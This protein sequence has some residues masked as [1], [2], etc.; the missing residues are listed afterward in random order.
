MG[1]IFNQ[2]VVAHLPEWGKGFREAIQAMEAL[3]QDPVFGKTISGPSLLMVNGQC[4]T[5]LLGPD[6]SKEGWEESD[7]GD[8]F[9]Q[10][11]LEAAALCERSSVLHW[12]MGGD[13]G[14]TQILFQTDEA[15][16]GDTEEA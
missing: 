9:R 5:W 12:T 3:Q 2:F 8:A 10:R 7:R 14:V 11:F 13:D 16:T 15:D 4:Q 6:G 1:Y